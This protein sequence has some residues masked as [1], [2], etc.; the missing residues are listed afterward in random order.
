MKEQIEKVKEFGDTFITTFDRDSII[1]TD[2]IDKRI[3]L[4]NVCYIPENQDQILS[5]MKFRR[6]HHVNFYFIDLETFELIIANGFQFI[7]KSI[8]DILHT[9]INT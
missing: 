4:N 8:N 2:T 1:L 5:L 3:T 6:E 7:D 9:F